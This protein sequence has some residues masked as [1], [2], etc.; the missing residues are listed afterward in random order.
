[1]TK[2]VPAYVFSSN[3]NRKGQVLGMPIALAKAKL[4]NLVGGK[5]S[6]EKFEENWNIMLDT[7]A[8]NSS[9]T[10]YTILDEKVGQHRLLASAQH[11]ITSFFCSIKLTLWD[12][13]LKN[14][15]NLMLAG[16]LTILALIAYST[17]QRSIY[18]RHIVSS[19]VEDVLQAIHAETDNHI[20][21]QARYPIAGLSIVQLKDHFLP[22]FSPQGTSSNRDDSIVDSQGRRL[23]YVTEPA[24]T[25]IWKRVSKDV[26]KNAN[27]RETSAHIKGEAH[28]VWMWIGSTA[29]S[30]TKKRK[31]EIIT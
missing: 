18:E 31:T 5:W 15:L 22:L 14:S 29:L 12:L 19:L 27:I 28:S 9:S 25:K 8:K 26:T 30:P 2:S 21:D 17:Y 23:W 3:S 24:R 10:L 11:S 20:Q 16:F 4:V 13:L 7:I 6:S 1:M